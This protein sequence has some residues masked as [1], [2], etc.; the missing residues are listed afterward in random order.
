MKSPKISLISAL[1]LGALIAFTPASRAQDQ[2]DT[3]KPSTPSATPPPSTQRPPRRGGANSFDTFAERLKLNDDQKTKIQ[4]LFREEAT[5]IRDIRQDTSLKPDEVREK[6][7]TTR[8][9]YMAKMKPILT[10]EQY[11]QLKTMRQQAGQRGRSP[12]QGGDAS[13]PK[14]STGSDQK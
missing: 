12:R 3:T 7:K 1:A 11:D 2:K 4:P 13:A 14:P 8:E 9:D 10:T 6:I 5:K